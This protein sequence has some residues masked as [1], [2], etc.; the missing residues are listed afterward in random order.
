MSAAHRGGD[1]AWIGLALIRGA[2][3]DEWR[4]IRRADET[5]KLVGGNGGG[6]GHAASLQLSGTRCFGV[7]PRGEVAVPIRELGIAALRLSR[8]EDMGSQLTW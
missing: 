7:S 5:H 3:I 1:K 2:N 8:S 6:R 4:T